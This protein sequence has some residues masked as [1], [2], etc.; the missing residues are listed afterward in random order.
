MKK[1]FLL[2]S[3][4]II[5][6]IAFAQTTNHS[7]SFD[8]LDEFKLGMTKAELEKILGKKIVL[9]IIG[10]EIYMETVDV[11]YKGTDFQLT[12]MR[13]QTP[14]EVARLESVST[15]SAAFKTPEGIGIGSDQSMI[16]DTYEMHLLIITKTS[17]TL[18]KIDDIHA[19]IVFYLE[20]KKVTEISVEPTAIFRDTE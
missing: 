16:I 19:S 10:D 9:K 20:N 6:F 14:S 5:F 1:I 15:K 3:L 18:V 8:G 12:L 2:L 7:A 17:I 4:V 11:S 13:S